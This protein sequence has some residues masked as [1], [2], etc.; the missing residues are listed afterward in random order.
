MR[1]F[2]V[3]DF[4]QPGSVMDLPDPEPTDGE[5]RIRVHSAS[6]NPFDGGV[7]QGT[8]RSWAETRLPLVPGVDA[9]GVIDAVGPGVDR[10]KPGDRVATN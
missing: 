1:G 7:A 8:T 9:A 10:F 2:A 3:T 5:I 4:D 6:V